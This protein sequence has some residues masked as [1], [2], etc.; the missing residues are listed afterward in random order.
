MFQSARSPE[1]AT[2]ARTGKIRTRQL[3]EIFPQDIIIPEA[4]GEFFLKIT[5]F[6]DDLLSRFYKIEPCFKY[7]DREQLIGELVLAL[8]PHTSAAIVGRIIGFT[9]A[10]ACFGHPY[11]HQTK[12]RNIDGDQ[13]SL[14]LLMDGLL[15]FSHSYLPASR[16]G[17]M[18]G[19]HPP[20]FS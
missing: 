20:R 7:Q 11:F 12:R 18:D 19:R 15:N 8:A 14:M 9:K 4:G 5:K 13:D 3:L 6:A 2:P 16:G 1:V 17:R 10:R